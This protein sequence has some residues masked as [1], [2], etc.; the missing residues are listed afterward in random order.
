MKVI[1]VA[2]FARL[3]LI[4]AVLAFVFGIVN[5]TGNPNFLWLLFLIISAEFIPVY[6]YKETPIIKEDNQEKF[7]R[8]KEQ[9]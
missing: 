5:L 9:E 3:C 1:I 8:P 7:N 4:I 6:K 2:I